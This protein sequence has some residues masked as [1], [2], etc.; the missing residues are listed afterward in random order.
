[1][2][3]YK[4]AELTPR[5]FAQWD[6]LVD[7]SVHGTVFHKT[8]WLDASA[9]ALGRKVKIFGCFQD[10]QILGG[11]SLFLEQ[12]WGLFTSAYSWCNTAPYGGFILS[13]SPSTSVHK[14][15]SF[16]RDIIE[17][18]LRAIEGEHFLYVSIQNSPEFLDIRSFTWNG[19]ESSVFY[20]YYIDLTNYL[21][22]NIDASLKRYIRKAEKSRIFIEPYSDISRYYDLYCETYTRKNKEPPV[23]QSLFTELYS[24]IKDN[25]CGE[26]IAAK[27]PEGEIACAEIIVWDTHQAFCWTAV[28]DSRFLNTGASTLIMNDYLKRLKDRGIPKINIMMANVPQLSSFA[29]YFNPTLV[30]CYEIRRRV[31]NNIRSLKINRFSF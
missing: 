15:E 6:A 24:F 19:W 2:N 12:K 28:S 20:A 18:L 10:D 13:P 8:G 11:C 21:E 30:P 29:S 3:K 16:S 27:T 23:P 22:A 17:S 5:D 25:N 4:V 26:M 14:K 1:M 9:R 31:K 7:Q